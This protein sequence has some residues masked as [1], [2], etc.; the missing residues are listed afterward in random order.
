MKVLVINELLSTLIDL[1]D[2]LIANQLECIIIHGPNV[3]PKY[4]WSLLFHH[5]NKLAFSN[6]YIYI[7]SSDLVRT[8]SY[9]LE[10]LTMVFCD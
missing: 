1:N 3:T 7:L 9:A 10:L 6:I 5:Q 2:L 8:S 4:K